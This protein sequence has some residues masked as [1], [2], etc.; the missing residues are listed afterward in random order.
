MFVYKQVIFNKYEQDIK[1]ALQTIY[2]IGKY[3]SFLISTKMGLALIYFL[4]D[5]NTYNLSLLTYLLDY[6]S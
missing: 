4:G 3:K 6:Y 5:L 1:A 2:G